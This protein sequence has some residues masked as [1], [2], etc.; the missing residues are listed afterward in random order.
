LIEAAG[1]KGF[2]IGDIMVSPKHANFLLNV[3]AATAA[4][5]EK[6]VAHIQEEV[7]RQFNVA[8][9]PEFRTVGSNA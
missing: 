4:D 2:R 7:Q 3:E 5:V 1:L 6:L 8:L 9:V